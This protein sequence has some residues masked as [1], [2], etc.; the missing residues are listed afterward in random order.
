MESDQAPE[1]KAKINRITVYVPEDVHF[2]LAYLKLRTGKPLNKIL[3][4]AILQ[5]LSNAGIDPKTLPDL[6]EKHFQQSKP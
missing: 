1:G 4:E 2:A 6:L 5:A 3:N